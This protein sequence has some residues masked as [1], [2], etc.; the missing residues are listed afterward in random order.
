MDTSSGST[1]QCLTKKGTWANFTNNAGTVTSV[2]IKGGTNI[3][4]DS[5]AAISS[6][7]T[8][9][10]SLSSVQTPL[11]A[12]S[13]TAATTTSPY[14]PSL[15]AFN[16]GVSSSQL[17][18]GMMVTVKIPVATTSYGSYISID[19]GTTYKPIVVG[20][21][22]G[23]MTTHYSV[24]DVITLFYD[25]AGSCVTYAITGASGTSTVSGGCW[26][27]LNYY[28]SGNSNDT[29]GYMRQMQNAAYRKTTAALYRYKL[30]LPHKDGIQVI[31]ANT[32][33]IQN[34]TSH[35]FSTAMTTITTE[36]FDITRPIEYYSTTGTVSAAGNIDGRY[37]WQMRSDVDLRYSFN[38]GTTL[39]A[40]KDVYLVAT[41]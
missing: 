11:I 31:P 4:V 10:I 12:A 6:S 30:L 33:D 1:T 20:T 34:N 35:P 2:T 19:N 18:T 36:E 7:G 29:A 25:A 32:S 8:R 15:W 21:S 37:H 13:S 26:R 40:G 14:K 9:T 17:A 38:T 23:R 24:D 39:T 5:E 3:D 28:D 22:T 16:L 41:L 27:V